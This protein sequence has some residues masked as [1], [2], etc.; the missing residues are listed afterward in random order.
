MDVNY[1]YDASEASAKTKVKIEQSLSNKLTELFN[2]HIEPAINNGE[3]Y[4]IVL[5][6]KF[7]D[8]VINWLK[9]QGYTISL[10]EDNDLKISWQ[11]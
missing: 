1:F 4:C 8:Q 5:K 9:E 6:T 10:E 11:K 7:S 2:V 3:F